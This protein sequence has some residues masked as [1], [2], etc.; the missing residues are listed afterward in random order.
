MKANKNAQ[1]EKKGNVKITRE[2]MKNREQNKDK[3]T[4]QKK[5]NTRSEQ[6]RNK[7]EWK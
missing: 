3:R 7:S 5:P 2:R 4:K 1:N 6:N